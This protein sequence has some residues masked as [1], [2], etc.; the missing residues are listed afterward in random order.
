[1]TNGTLRP[2]PVRSPTSP[3]DDLS[4]SQE[5][6]L[7]MFRSVMSKKKRELTDD[8]YL[9][10]EYEKEKEREDGVVCGF[11]LMLGEKGAAYERYYLPDTGHNYNPSI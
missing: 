1:M 2:P 10:Q 4:P 5:A 9:E 11:I 8:D 6:A 7:A 3:G